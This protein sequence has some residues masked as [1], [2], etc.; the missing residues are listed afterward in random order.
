MVGFY[1]LL[2]DIRGREPGS[3]SSS[4]LPLLSGVLGTDEFVSA[5]VPLWYVT[6]NLRWTEDSMTVVFISDLSRLPSPTFRAYGLLSLE[7]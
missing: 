3:T 2:E 5:M 4:V 6:M 1:Q 7:S